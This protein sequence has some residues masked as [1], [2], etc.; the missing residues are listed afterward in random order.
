MDPIRLGKDDLDD[1]FPS[2]PPPVVTRPGGVANSA[3]D[4]QQ[5]G[6]AVVTITSDNLGNT[7]RGSGPALPDLSKPWTPEQQAE[8]SKMF[9]EG[10]QRVDQLKEDVRRGKVENEAA[11]VGAMP[12]PILLSPEDM[13]GMFPAA[14]GVR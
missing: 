5:G 10:Q 6:P 8:A 11:G 12:S 1:E 2:A 14:P 13:A 4:V 3:A 9:A 7:V